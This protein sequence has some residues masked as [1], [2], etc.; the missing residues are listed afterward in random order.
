MSRAARRF[1][2][3]SALLCSGAC[4]EDCAAPRVSYW[5]WTFLCVLKRGIKIL[6]GAGEY[7]FAVAGGEKGKRFLRQFQ[8]L[9]ERF[10]GSREIRASGDARSAEVRNDT[11]K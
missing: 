5:P 1:R 6:R 4:Q 9:G 8:E 3:S 2:L 11:A 7:P 10:F